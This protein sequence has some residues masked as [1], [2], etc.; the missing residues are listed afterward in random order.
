MHSIYG[1][2]IITVI[3]L[4]DIQNMLFKLLLLPYEIVALE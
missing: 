4:A 1:I 3:I 2:I